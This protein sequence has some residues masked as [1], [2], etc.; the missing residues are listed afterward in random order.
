[1]TEIKLRSYI[2]KYN[3]NSIFGIPDPKIAYQCAKNYKSKGFDY[4]H[5]IVMET[6]KHPE[7]LDVLK[8]YLAAFPDKI[9][10]QNEKGWTALHLACRNAR[11]ASTERTVELLLTYP[12]INVNLKDKNG[13]T[14]FHYACANSNKD[15]SER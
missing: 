10:C 3:S 15:S 9:N 4:I 13:N 7:A 11:I 6:N 14:A 1:M 12:G 8:N 5:K 2:L